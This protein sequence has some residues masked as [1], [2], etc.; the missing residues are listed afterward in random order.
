MYTTL[1]DFHADLE[2]AELLLSMTSLLKEFSGSRNFDD[3]L[4]EHFIRNKE[5]A[6]VEGITVSLEKGRDTPPHQVNVDEYLLK[7]T[8]LQ[9]C[10]KVNHSNLVIL[11]STLLLFIVGR[12]ESF[13]RETFEEFCKNIVIRANK[14][15]Q[16]PK[17]MRDN[18]IRYTSD[19]ISNPRKYGHAENGVKS[20]V[21]ILS[22]NLTDEEDLEEVN[23]QCLSITHDNMRPDIFNDL[24][25]RVGV[26]NIWE[27]ISQQSEMQV[28]FQTSDP[29]QTKN[30][31]E[32]FLNILMDKRNSI[33]H[34]SRSV[35]WSDSEYI[36][37]SLKFFKALSSVIIISLNSLEFDIQAKMDLSKN[38]Q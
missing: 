25:K 5:K 36:S 3:I 12:F 7:I 15:S 27:K 37:T 26:K 17:D 21:R 22:K 2:K 16:L 28:H 33:A 18:L 13:V 30:K 4:N 6:E 8:S 9:A 10:S 20:F 23:H 11:N 19:V 14:F 1:G 24:F 29:N 34:P 31:A 38:P 35:T 32:T